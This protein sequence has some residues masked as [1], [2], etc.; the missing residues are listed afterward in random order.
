MQQVG[1][2]HANHLAQ[3]LKTDIQQRDSDLLIYIQSAIDSSTQSDA[4]SLTG[5]ITTSDMSTMTPT[6][7]QANATRTDT[8]Q[9]EM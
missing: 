9:L 6:E 7:R 2:H 8:V 5:T 3:P 1:Y 4:G